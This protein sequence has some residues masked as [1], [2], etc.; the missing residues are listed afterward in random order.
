MPA[1]AQRTGWRILKDWVAAQLAIIEAGLA[2][3]PEVMLPYALL[4]DGQTLY[5]R[6]QA[7]RTLLLN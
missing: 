2:T 3:L 7:D 1:G 4:S 5:K 6:V